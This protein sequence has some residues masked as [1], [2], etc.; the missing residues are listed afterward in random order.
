MNT[1]PLCN[2]NVASWHDANTVVGSAATPFC[3]SG[4]VLASAMLAWTSVSAQVVY[5]ESS[6]F[7]CASQLGYC[8]SRSL[9]S[10]GSL[11]LSKNGEWTRPSDHASGSSA[12]NSKADARYG[13][14]QI[15]TSVSTSGAVSGFGR[16]G[17]ETTAGAQVIYADTILVDS[18]TLPPGSPVSIRLDQLIQ[19][20]LKSAS[21]ASGLFSFAVGDRRL[22]GSLDVW[23]IH[24]A[25]LVHETWCSKNGDYYGTNPSCTRPLLKNRGS[26]TYSRQ[27]EVKVGD[28]LLVEASLEAE[29]FG[30]MSCSTGSATDSCSVSASGSTDGPGRSS[31]MTTSFTP[32]TPGVALIGDSGH[33]WGS[34][35]LAQPH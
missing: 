9:S 8:K 35:A 14:A 1:P 26:A 19:Q 31:S 13:F 32:L 16:V 34:S 11:S 24:G 27:L 20:T 23:I 25:Q 3:R 21:A 10:E 18:A 33:V 7:A 17:D 12:I 6:V 28:R 15:T 5:F 29:S 22:N 4:L 2:E 30:Q